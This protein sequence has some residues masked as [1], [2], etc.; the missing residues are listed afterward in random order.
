MSYKWNGYGI[1]IVVEKR[2]RRTKALRYRN[3]KKKKIC[4]VCHRIFWCQQRFFSN[5]ASLRRISLQILVKS[6]SKKFK[7]I[8]RSILI[9][10]SRMRCF[11][12]SK[13]LL[14]FWELRF[15][16]STNFWRDVLRKEYMKQ[17]SN[18]N[19]FLYQ[20]MIRKN[21]AKFKHEKYL[22]HCLNS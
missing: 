7:F 11:F 19:V 10:S 4:D 12:F 17:N 22:R 5:S 14:T 18:K 13:E 1:N 8:W 3:T 15:S 20:K 6:E 9:R 2:T 16:D 21:I